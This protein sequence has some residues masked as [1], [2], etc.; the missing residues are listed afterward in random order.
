MECHS[1]YFKKVSDPAKPL[2]E[3]DH[4]K[5]LFGV[6]CEKCHG[7]AAMHVE[8]QSKNPDI[9][10]AKYIVNPGKLSRDR[11]LD[12]CALCHGGPLTKSQPSFT[13]QAGDTLANYFTLNKAIPDIANI[14]VHG[15]QLGLLSRSKCF[16]SSSLTCLNCHNTHENENGKIEVFSQRCMTCHSKDHGRECRMTAAIGPIITQ[17]CIDCHMPKQPSHA[18]SVY[19]QD[20]LI[21]TP[22]LM[23][24]HYITVYPGET[25]KIQALLTNLQKQNSQ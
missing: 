6:D 2:E 18:V 20:S 21:A 4:N 14:D 16:I 25:K 8:F 11:I 19:L 24:T 15:N 10:E 1:T 9:K 5:I 3:F 23:R 7:P 17:D 22:A 12:L 13:F